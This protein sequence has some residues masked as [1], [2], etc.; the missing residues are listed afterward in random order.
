MTRPVYVDVEEVG[1]GVPAPTG[2]LIDKVLRAGRREVQ[3]YQYTV[4]KV[5]GG[6]VE[7]PW[8][9][10]D[11]DDNH[12]RHLVGY[13]VH[14]GGDT[15]GDTE[16]GLGEDAR[17]AQANALDEPEGAAFLALGGGAVRGNER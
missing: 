6:S 13:A 10:G 8:G 17:E 2:A 4:Q 11:A 16:D 12:V 15:V 3:G 7:R 9:A 5:R 14:D 1:V